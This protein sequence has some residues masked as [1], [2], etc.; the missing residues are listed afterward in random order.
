MTDAPTQLGSYE[1]E[2][3]IGRGGMGVVYRARD[4]RLQRTVAIKMLP[5]EVAGDPERLGRFEREARILASLRHP[6][7]AGIYSI[8][9]AGDTHYLALEYVEGPTLADRLEAGPLPVAEALDV[10]RQIAAALEAAHEAGVIHRDLKPGNVKITP[11]G[12]VKVLDFGLARMEEPVESPSLSRS[13]TLTLAAT[14]VGVVMGTAAY[15]SPEQARGRPVDRRTDIWSFGCVLY[16]CLTGRQQFPGETVSDSIARILE[17][18]TDLSLLPTDVPVRVRELL[19]RCLAKDPRERLRDIGDAR[20]VLE[21]ALQSR[22]PSGRF[23]PFEPRRGAMPNAAPIAVA[24][25]A[26]AALGIGAG[27][28]IAPRIHPVA[29]PLRAVSISMPAGESIRGS[30]LTMDGRTVMVSASPRDSNASGGGIVRLLARPIGSDEFHEVAGTEGLFNSLTEPDGRTLLLIAPVT[31]GSAQKRLVRLPLDGSAPATP[32]A[33]WR[34]SWNTMARLDNG[35]V[36]V[37]DGLFQF[38]RI[39][40]NGGDPSAPRAMQVTRAGKVSEIDFVPG[41]VPGG[42]FANVIAY[43][44]RGW[45]YSVGMLDPAS[46]HVNVVV[47]DGGNPIYWRKR[48]ILFFARARSIFAARFDPARHALRSTP[49]AVWSGL[50]TNIEARPGFF[51]V[52]DDGSLYYAPADRRA[53]A[54]SASWTRRATSRR[55]PVSAARSTTRRRSRPMAIASC[56]RSR[57][58]VASTSCGSATSAAAASAASARIPMPIARNRRGRRTARASPTSARRRT[59]VTASTCRT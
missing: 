58:R 40:R 19:E 37:T 23:T 11:G 43:D 5:P 52:L 56:A 24:A 15:M 28:A 14:R 55:G 47:D 48:G 49:V 21:E 18:A 59:R 10:A 32:V 26:A 30:S 34:D 39:P 4:V 25:I 31:A 9:D 44:S 8:E 22:T 12:D 7:I 50:R 1:V 33:D 3:E 16:E 51:R 57:T 42:A 38:V 20:L 35:D 36:V 27:L 2:G 13:P 17:R 6:G 53:D 46:G 41:A 29:E 54:G 45:H